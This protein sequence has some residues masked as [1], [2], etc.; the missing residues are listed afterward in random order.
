L[1]AS[2]KA[3]IEMV[4]RLISGLRNPEVAVAVV[5]LA[6]RSGR[7]EH[8]SIGDDGTTVDVKV[9]VT[10]PTRRPIGDQVARLVAP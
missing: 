9:D 7:V 4:R 6:D 8:F 5:I 1:E 10:Q 3:E 2:V